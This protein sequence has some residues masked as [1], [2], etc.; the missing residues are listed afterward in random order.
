MKLKIYLVLFAALF[1]VMV[2]SETGC[3]I[4]LDPAGV[5]H[6]NTLL[7]DADVTIDTTHQALESFVSWEAAND[8]FLITNAPAITRAADFVRKNG[9]GWLKTATLA[10]NKYED[11]VLSVSASTND[12]QSASNT[13]QQAVAGLKIDAANANKQQTFVTIP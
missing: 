7:Y 1:G 10:R 8:S 3:K 13:L 5:Y 4:K 6:G 9:P 12:V 2:L 11:S